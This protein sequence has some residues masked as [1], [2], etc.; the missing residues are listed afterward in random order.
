MRRQIISALGAVLFP[1]LLHADPVTIVNTGPGPSISSGGLE[2]SGLQWIAVEFD[3]STPAVIT[4]IEGWMYGSRGGSLDIALYADGG[5]IPG[6]SLFRE[7]GL[8]SAGTVGWR[9]LSGLSWTVAPGT[10][11][12]GF[13]A[14]GGGPGPSFLGAMPRPSERPL[15]NGA[16]VDPEFNLDYFAQDAVAGVGVR[17]FAETDAAPVPEP[18]SMLLIA[19]GLA[20][21]L[22]RRYWHGT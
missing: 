4:S 16:L 19:S 5:E 3:V 11:W 7:T 9:G 15:L 6:A 1:A 20:G 12:V 22:T 10:Y 17:V 8:I 14:R 21:V 13:E 2:L 18:A